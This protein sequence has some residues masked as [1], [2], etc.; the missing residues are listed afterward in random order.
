M[1]VVQFLTYVVIDP[2]HKSSWSKSIMQLKSLKGSSSPKA[3]STTT[4]IHHNHRIHA[5][6]RLTYS[7]H[8]SK[9]RLPHSLSYKELA[10]QAL[11]RKSVV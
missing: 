6:H 4:Y 7:L 5:K 1:N 3:L 11:D 10:T 2:S 8:N 9:A